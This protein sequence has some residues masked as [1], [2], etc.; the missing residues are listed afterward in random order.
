MISDTHLLIVLGIIL[1]PILVLAARASVFAYRSVG[2]V[3]VT[4]VLG[5]GAYF[6]LQHFY[7]EVDVVA[8]VYEL[9]SYIE[10]IKAPEGPHFKKG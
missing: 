8:K 10:N 2:L 7:P 1:L 6:G 3:A 9:I 4:A 5:A